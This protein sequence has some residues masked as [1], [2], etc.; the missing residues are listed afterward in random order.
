MIKKM[1]KEKKQ[2]NRTKSNSQDDSWK[3]AWE[4]DVERE[5]LR[6]PYERVPA[7]ALLPRSSG[8]FPSIASH[9]FDNSGS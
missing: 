1:K 6:G 3:E 7:A 2:K 4:S 5:R 8:A 9:L